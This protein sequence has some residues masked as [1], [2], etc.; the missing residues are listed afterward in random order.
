MAHS[1][2]RLSQSTQVDRIETPRLH[3]DPSD[4]NVDAVAQIRADEW[5][6]AGH[7]HSH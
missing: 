6:P 7:F 5:R 1:L 3:P 2:L 4:Q